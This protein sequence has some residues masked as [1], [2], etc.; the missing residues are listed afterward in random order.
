MPH[1]SSIPLSIR[2]GDQFQYILLDVARAIAYKPRFPL[3]KLLSKT[4]F[5]YTA[6]TYHAWNTIKIKMS[7]SSLLNGWGTTTT[8]IPSATSVYTQ[9]TSC[10]SNESITTPPDLNTLNVVPVNELG[11]N[12]L[13]S[14]CHAPVI[15]W[16]GGC[17]IYCTQKN[18]TGLQLQQC[19]NNEIHI[20][21]EGFPNDTQIYETF[22]VSRGSSRKGHSLWGGLFVAAVV[23]MALAADG[24]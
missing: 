8:L 7:S 9:P 22:Y 24:I 6:A 3:D 12:V 13:A 11:I 2:L 21:N 18:L 17:S 16:Q 19:F 1:A 14:C 15:L 10:P 23:V 4:D 20:H 5:R